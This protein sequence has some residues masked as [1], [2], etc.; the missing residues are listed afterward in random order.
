MLMLAPHHTQNSSEGVPCR[1]LRGTTLIPLV[2]MLHARSLA[3]CSRVSPAACTSMAPSSPHVCQ[4]DAPDRRADPH[5]S[6][7]LWTRPDR[8]GWVA[9]GVPFCPLHRSRMKRFGSR[10]WA[11]LVVDELRALCDRRIAESA[12][13]RRE[14]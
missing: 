11:K 6:G 1:S 3:G 7:H 12:A 5:L 2:S 13:R 8:A 9:R 10:V 4:H 14:P